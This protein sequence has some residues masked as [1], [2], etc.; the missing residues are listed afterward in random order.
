MYTYMYRYVDRLIDRY[1]VGIHVIGRSSSVH[2]KQDTA[3]S[4]SSSSPEAGETSQAPPRRGPLLISTES[5]AKPAETKIEFK[6]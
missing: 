2:P 4:W 5:C 1:L 3:K 6:L